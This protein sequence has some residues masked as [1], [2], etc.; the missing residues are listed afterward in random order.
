MSALTCEPDVEV[1]AICCN[2]TEL[3]AAVAAWRPDVIVTDIRMPPSGSDEGLRAVANLRETN[4]NIGVV[5]LSQYAEPAY[6]LALLESG[7]NQR[8]YLLKERIRSRSDLVAAIKAVAHGG[9]VVD[10]AIVDVLIDARARMAH[11]RLSQLTPRERQ[12]LGE[13]ATGKS[14]TAIAEDLFLTKRAVEKHV[15]SIF[16]KLDLPESEDVSRRVKAA[17]LYLAEGSELS[18]VHVSSGARPNAGGTVGPGP[19]V[20]RPGYPPQAGGADRGAA[21]DA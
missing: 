20:P 13:I 12:L 2:G 1:V 16:A 6:V 19:R 15:N 9:S 21:S 4:P 7:T 18:G 5:V 3:S 14:N 11:S 10:P 8:A 17:L